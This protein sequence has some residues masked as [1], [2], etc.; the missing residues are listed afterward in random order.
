M[1]LDMWCLLRLVHSILSRL[2]SSKRYLIVGEMSA[3]TII[4]KYDI[5][6]SDNKRGVRSCLV[7]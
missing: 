3:A 2:S 7:K 1:G 6:P 5:V 4:L